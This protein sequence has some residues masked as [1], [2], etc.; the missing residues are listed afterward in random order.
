MRLLLVVLCGFLLA[1]CA[2]VSG[3]LKL[4]FIGVSRFTS[5]N[6]AG[7]GAG[8]T[9][10]TS[11]YTTVD[12]PPGAQNRLMQFTATV[13]YTPQRAPFA[14]P[15]PIN[16]FINNVRPD[17]LVTYVDTMLTASPTTNFLF[18]PVFGVRTT[19]GTER[20]TFTASD[21]NGNSAARAFVL[22]VRRSDS[23]AVYHDYTLK[24]R[25]PATTQSDRRFIDLKSGLAL[26]AYS[27]L[28]V[29]RPQTML[30]QAKLQQLTDMVVLP[31]GLGLASPDAV[32]PLD[33]TRWPVANRRQ[34]RF[35]LTN[36]LPTDYNSAQDVATIKGQFAGT[37]LST[38]TTLV[39][40]QVYAFR[41]FKDDGKTPVY[42]L[43]RVLSLPNGTNAVGLQLQ[44]RV[45]K[46]P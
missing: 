40:D 38:I 32:T 44:I 1:G 46:Q 41:A 14:Y 5:G 22:A 17:S 6:R 3:P 26:P 29:N 27:V 34:T 28:G 7:L 39:K 16:L 45:A 18:T 8:D 11:L 33:G 12:N 31:N 30:D 2:K 20:W 24:L 9:L 13:R 36:Y 35:V 10:A 25:V 23:L 21:N 15:V 42:G 19:S 37:M 4:Y 43:M